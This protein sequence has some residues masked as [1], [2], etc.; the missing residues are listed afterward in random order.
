VALPVYQSG[1]D[2]ECAGSPV[3]GQRASCWALTPEMGKTIV[4]LQLATNALVSLL[5]LA[6]T[7]SP[8]DGKLTDPTMQLV[9]TVWRD[10]A[11]NWQLA[12]AGPNL[13][14]ADVAPQ[15]AAIAQFFEGAKNEIIAIK[16]RQRNALQRSRS[17]PATSSA[18]GAA[19]SSAAA[20]G[21]AAGAG[22]TSSGPSRLPLFLIVAGV[23]AAGAGLGIARE[24][25][26]VEA[27]MAHL[28]RR[29]RR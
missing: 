12:P 21:A 6:V 10:L 16:K 29:G 20:G 4:R 17:T 9:A 25:S 5:G 7:P 13:D 18:S 14:L 28:R 15:A 24:L 19:T 27:R 2:F 1:I 3:F 11:L 22:A 8:I 26:R 23:L